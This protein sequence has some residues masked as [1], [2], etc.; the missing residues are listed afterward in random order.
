VVTIQPPASCSSSLHPHQNQPRLPLP[1]RQPTQHIQ[2]L[3]ELL[4]GKTALNLPSPAVPAVLLRCPT[5][6]AVQAKISAWT[7]SADDPLYRS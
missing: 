5:W 7:G 4:A 6:E 3:A 1:E 2:A